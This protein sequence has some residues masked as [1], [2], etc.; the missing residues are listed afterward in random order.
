MSGDALPIDP[1][2]NPTRRLLRGASVGLATGFVALAVSIAPALFIQSV[3]IG[4]AQR[5]GEQQRFEAAALDQVE[6]RCEEDLADT[7]FWFPILIVV[8]GTVIGA[9]GGFAY[10]YAAPPMP[11]R[12][13]RLPTLGRY[14]QTAQARMPSQGND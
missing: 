8:V 7:P 12:G 6:T 2:G 13:R 11:R 3:F 14:A 9:T 4:S 1:R 5:C 10:G